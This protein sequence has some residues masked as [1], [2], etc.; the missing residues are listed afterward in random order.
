M[1]QGDL[2]NSSNHL[3]SNQ[4]DHSQAF[5]TAGVLGTSECVVLDPDLLRFDVHAF[6][7]FSRC[8][9]CFGDPTEV[10]RGDMGQGAQHILPVGK[11]RAGG[12]PPL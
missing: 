4:T 5:R 9:V 10:E 2:P 3:L 11:T 6:P 1:G 12:R 7:H 8:A